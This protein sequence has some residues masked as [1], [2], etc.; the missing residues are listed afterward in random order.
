MLY[1]PGPD[2]DTRALFETGKCKR[3]SAVTTAATRKLAQLDSAQTLEPLAAWQQ[4]RS[5]GRC[6][7]APA[8]DAGRHWNALNHKTG[9]PKKLIHMRR[10]FTDQQPLRVSVR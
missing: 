7:R 1:A 3:F 8:L 6:E 2:C 10:R 9:S 4:V 5:A